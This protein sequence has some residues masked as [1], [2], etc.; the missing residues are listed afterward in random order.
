MLAMICL[1]RK[2][3]GTTSTIGEIAASENIPPR[4]LERILLQLKNR[5]F[6]SSERGKTGGYRLAREPREISL[7]DIVL[8]FEGSVSMLSCVCRERYRH[9][10]FC[11]D[12][13]SCPIRSTFSAVYSHTVDILR[14]TTLYDLSR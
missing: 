6:L 11:K 2:D 12:E 4:V 9:C 14:S 3:D 1:A 8:V 13:L 10:E 5:G 7:L